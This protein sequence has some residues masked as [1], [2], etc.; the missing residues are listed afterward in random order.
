MSLTGHSSAV[1]NITFSSNEDKIVTGSS[2]GAIK[3]WDLRQAESIFEAHEQ[4]E[5]IT[6]LIYDDNY[7][8]LIT[9]SLDG[10]VAIYD[11]KQ[12]K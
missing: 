11:L 3:V 5:A 2:T 12:G 7:S 4:S 1:T 8:N 6:G 9:S 10:T